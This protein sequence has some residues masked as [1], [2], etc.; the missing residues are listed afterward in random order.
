VLGFF[1]RA[2]VFPLKARDLGE[3]LRFRQPSGLKLEPGGESRN[4]VARSQ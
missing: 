4:E 1:D 3:T 2:A